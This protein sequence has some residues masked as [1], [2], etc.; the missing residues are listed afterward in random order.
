MLLCVRARCLREREREEEV[1]VQVRP[2][3][4]A[5]VCVT[6][7]EGERFEGTTEVVCEMREGERDGREKTEMYD[8]E[9]CV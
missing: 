8:Y 5:S 7:K 6:Q 1:C 9:A 2:C 4:H 3:V